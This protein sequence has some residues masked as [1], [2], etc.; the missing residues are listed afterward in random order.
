MPSKSNGSVAESFPRWEFGFWH[1]GKY[2][3]CQEQPF[4]FSY[5]PELLNFKLLIRNPCKYFPCQ[6]QMFRF[7]YFPELQMWAGNLKY[8]GGEVSWKI[9]FICNFIGCVILSNVSK[10]SNVLFLLCNVMFKFCFTH[11]KI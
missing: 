4:K 3:T 7:W 5:F 1:P 9:C 8:G 2:F 6:E 11:L 10:R